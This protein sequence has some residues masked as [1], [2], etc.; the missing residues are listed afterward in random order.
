MREGDHSQTAIGAAILRAAHQV[1]DEPRIIDDPIATGFVPGSSRDEILAAPNLPGLRIRG[2]F[3]M[4][5]RYAEDC[6]RE[7]FD[8][9][10]RQYVVLGAGMDTLAYRQPAWSSELKVFE[11]DHPATQAWKRER[12][13]LRSIPIPSNLVF[14]P[15]DFETTDLVGCLQSASF[16][17]G[18]PAFFSWLGVTQYITRDAIETTLRLIAS[19]PRESGVVFEF[20]VPDSMLDG[21]DLAESQALQRLTTDAGEPWITKL[22][23]EEWRRW[24]LAL[25]FSS[26][27]HLTPEIANERYFGN[28][29]D[30]LSAPRLGQML[31]AT[32]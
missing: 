1:L 21:Q 6:L 20:V 3:A 26:V 27:F 31:L 30:G 29:K 10:V 13:G 17:F 9:G 28:R 5:S 15:C 2:L 32:V 24:L 19:M 14:A 22:A 16:D 7:A 8:R 18:I 11:V 25:G 4:R 23:P 12:L